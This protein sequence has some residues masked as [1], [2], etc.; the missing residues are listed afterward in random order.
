[1][2]R[3]LAISDVARL[4]ANIPDLTGLVLVGGQALNFWAESLQIAD[5]DSEGAYGAALSQDIDF[6]GSAKAAEEIAKAVSGKLKLAGTGN[7]HSPNTALV[8]FNVDGETYEID[9]LWHLQGFSPAELQQDGDAWTRAVQ[10]QLTDQATPLRIMHPVHCLQS[11]LENIYGALKRRDEP[12]GNRYVPRVRLAVEAS[13]RICIKYLDE[14]DVRSALSVAETIHRLSLRPSALR[15][16]LQDD[17]RVDDA[18]VIDPRMPASFLERRRPQMRE[19]LE[20]K[21]SKFE[22]A[23]NRRSKPKKQ[24]SRSGRKN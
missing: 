18:I 7:P 3:L 4:V 14:G 16:R 20:N 5:A 15:A 22:R 17:V 1:M 13:R 24:S 19:Q 11:Q 6:L 23:Q 21:L 12:D 8:T 2:K 10:L 9:F